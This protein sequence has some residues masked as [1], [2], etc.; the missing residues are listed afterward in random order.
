MPNIKPRKKPK[1]K[2]PDI[3]K[4][5]YKGRISTTWRY[6]SGI[7][8]MV[9]LKI[10][11]YSKQP[12]SGYGNPRVIRGKHPSGYEEVRVFNPKEVE[13]VDPD[14]QAIRIAKQVGLKKSLTIQNKA[15]E[16]GVVILNPKQVIDE[17][18]PEETAK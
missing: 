16:L 13:K 8:N 5:K 3:G 6:P 18:L 17:D 4:R 14:Y 9:R 12:G 15:D 7:D 2:R 11:G 1:F 10:R